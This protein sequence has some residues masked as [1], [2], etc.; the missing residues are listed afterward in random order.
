MALR[1]FRV[2]IAISAVVFACY[3]FY[4]YYYSGNL[5]GT[6]NIV[7][8]KY[9][10]HTKI[11][12]QTKA[13]NAIINN[14]AMG[15][16]Y[17]HAGVVFLIGGTGVGKTLALSLIR[18]NYEPSEMIMNLQQQDLSSA[19]SME[20][21]KKLARVNGEGLVTIDNADV[22]STELWDF[23]NR[24]NEFC[25]QNHN[26]LR[27]KVLIASQIFQDVNSSD[28]N[29]ISNAFKNSDEYVNYI[30]EKYTNACG[31]YVNCM[32]V[33][34]KPIGI[35]TLEMCIN[36]TAKTLIGHGMALNEEQVTT[37]ID[38]I[39]ESGLDYVPSGCKSVESNV[40]LVVHGYSLLYNIV[41]NHSTTIYSEIMEIL[42]KAFAIIMYGI[43]HIFFYFLLLLFRPL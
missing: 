18:E 7:Q 30:K 35:D 15:P 29:L 31:G 3:L 19:S 17:N 8:L 23:V 1:K 36:A 40:A 37:L 14:L 12:G 6:F 33:L 21:V 38:Q 10:L 5:Q 28:K 39:S 22:I 25:V 26:R 20:Q 4:Y 2:L 34:F 11:F 16:H 27:V 24:L 32:A 43:F 41:S 42:I 9:D 13:L